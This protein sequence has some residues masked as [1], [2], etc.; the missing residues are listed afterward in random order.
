MKSSKWVPRT[1]FGTPTVSDGD[2]LALSVFN[3]D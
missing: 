2:K 1:I 3:L